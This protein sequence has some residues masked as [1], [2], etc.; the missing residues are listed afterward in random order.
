MAEGWECPKAEYLPLFINQRVRLKQKEEKFSDYF[1]IIGLYNFL[2]FVCLIVMQKQCF[3]NLPCSKFF[4]DFY[5]IEK[6][7]KFENNFNATK[8]ILQSNKICPQF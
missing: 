3:S 4:Y 6:N 1:L 2:L 5:P 8:N 7:S